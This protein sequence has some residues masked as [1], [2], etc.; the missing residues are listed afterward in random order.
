M[1]PHPSTIAHTH[2][3][4]EGQEQGNSNGNGTGTVQVQS[5]KKQKQQ[6]EFQVSNRISTFTETVFSEFTS[7]AQ[8]T[9]SVNLGM[10]LYIDY[11]V[12]YNTLHCTAL[13]A[14]LY[15]NLYVYEA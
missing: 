8:K 13:H 14:C 1:K 2:T 11:T 9:G 5:T 6:Q 15:S 4:T 12:T 3:H 7:L 10:C